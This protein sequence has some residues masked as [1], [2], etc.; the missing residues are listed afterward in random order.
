MA[1]LTVDFHTKSLARRTRMDLFIPSLNLGGCLKNQ[2]PQYYRN[3]P[4]TYPLVVFLHGFGDNE[5]AWQM[6]TQILKLC[7]DHKIAACFINGENKWYLNMGPIEDYYTLVEEEVLDFLYGNFTYLSEDQP[8]VIAGVSMGGYGALY[9]YLKNVDKY[10]ACVALS[11]AI[12]PDRLDET[13][14]GTLR[15]LFLENQG[16]A[17]NVYLSVG[18]SDFIIDSSRAFNDFLLENKLGVEYKFIPDADHSW[19]TWAQEI[20]HVIKYLENIIKK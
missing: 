6:N 7:E 9:H 11:P 18:E 19:Y 12:R 5:K 3:H 13:K 15:E 16:K 4:Q 10:A 2:D 1:L 14:F 20:F 17:L 8:L